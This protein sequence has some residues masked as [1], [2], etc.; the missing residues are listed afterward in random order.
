MLT[1]YYKP[2]KNWWLNL[3]PRVGTYRSS[4]FVRF[5]MPR[6][7]REVGSYLS[8]DGVTELPIDGPCANPPSAIHATMQSAGFECFERLPLTAD[9]WEVRYLWARVVAGRWTLGAAVLLEG[10]TWE[11]FQEHGEVRA[12]CAACVCSPTSQIGTHLGAPLQLPTTLSVR[13]IPTFAAASSGATAPT[14][15]H[16]DIEAVFVIDQQTPLAASFF[17]DYVNPL[18]VA[19]A[20]NLNSASPMTRL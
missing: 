4:V 19:T 17:V 6:F 15:T 3:S 8:S 5:R 10:S 9:P 11:F 18:V 13:T 1:S 12:E 16:S 2:S 7:F 20:S 14:C